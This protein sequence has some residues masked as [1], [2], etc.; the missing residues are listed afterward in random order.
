M[1]IIHLLADILIGA[2]EAPGQSR[3]GYFYLR[4]M[5]TSE[6]PRDPELEAEFLRR[7][8]VRLS[9][10]DA[11]QAKAAVA[12]P[13]VDPAAAP[14]SADGGVRLVK[15]GDN[16]HINIDEGFDRAWRRVGLALD[17]G[18][19]TVE[20][21]DRSQGIF[22]VRYID[23]EADARNSGKP[24]F[25]GRLFSSKDKDTASSRQYR[26]KVTGGEGER[27]QVGVLGREGQ[28]VSTDADRQTVS[29]ILGLLADQLRQ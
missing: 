3:A 27:S 25:F 9:G 11:Q 4:R 2:M 10:A 5:D 17:R 24:G 28:Q 29:R 19:F 16:A 18:S 13:V 20:D 1:Y 22:Y 21:R 14:P 8:V 7:L 23:P 6:R 26:I 15:D 12:K